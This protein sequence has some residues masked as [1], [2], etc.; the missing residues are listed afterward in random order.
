MPRLIQLLLSVP[1]FLHAV[2]L[3]TN[4]NHR[5]HLERLPWPFF[6]GP[7]PVAFMR[8]TRLRRLCV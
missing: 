1:L 3:Y 4:T 2:S 6:G 8:A 5:D 7:R